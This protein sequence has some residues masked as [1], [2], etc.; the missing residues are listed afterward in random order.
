M[1]PLDSPSDVGDKPV[2][3]LSVADT[4]LTLGLAGCGLRFGP[5]LDAGAVGMCVLVAGVLVAGVLAADAAGALVV[6]PAGEAVA[7]PALALGAEPIPG[8]AG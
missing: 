7:D 8:T 4:V 1:S 5:A 6:D 3:P 2:W